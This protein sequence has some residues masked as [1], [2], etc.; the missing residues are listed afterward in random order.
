MIVEVMLSGAEPSQVHFGSLVHGRRKN[1]DDIDNGHDA[2]WSQD[3]NHA[4][5]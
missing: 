1:C 5:T 4:F 3:H 2:R